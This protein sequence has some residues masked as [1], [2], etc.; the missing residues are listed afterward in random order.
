MSKDNYISLDG[1][2]NLAQSRLGSKIV[3]KTDEFFAPAKR[4]LNP[5]S[6]V[7]KEGIFV[8]EELNNERAKGMAYDCIGNIHWHKGKYDKSL[9]NLYISL[10][11]QTYF[12]GN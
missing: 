7:F 1:L 9:E 5:W 3:Y 10:F 11:Q 4:I 12:S 2:I 8:A 6:P